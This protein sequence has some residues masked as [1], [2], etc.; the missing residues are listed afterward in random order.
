[1]PIC[2]DVRFDYILPTSVGAV[3]NRE[4]FGYS[5]ESIAASQ[6][7][8]FCRRRLIEPLHTDPERGAM[9]NFGRYLVVYLASHE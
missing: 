7:A 4:R 1:M 9:D 3:I 6:T 8:V 2:C 5:L